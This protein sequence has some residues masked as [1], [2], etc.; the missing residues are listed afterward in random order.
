MRFVTHTVI[1]SICSFFCTAQVRDTT[2]INN[3]NAAAYSLYMVEADSAILL[4][5]K[6]LELSEQ[7]NYVHGKGLSYLTLSK[8]YWG[9]GNFK[10]STEYGFKALKIFENT[11]WKKE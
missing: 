5:L 2:L 3:L 6:A 8:A 9:K 4:S 10:L 7:S 1:F 11:P